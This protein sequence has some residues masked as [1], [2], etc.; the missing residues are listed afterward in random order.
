MRVFTDL[1]L[2]GNTPM[3]VQQTLGEWGPTDVMATRGKKRARWLWTAAFVIMVAGLF[4]FGAWVFSIIMS[5][6]G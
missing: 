6:G 5:I 1:D 4:A 2:H 3:R